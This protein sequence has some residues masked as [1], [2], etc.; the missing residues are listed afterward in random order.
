M[1]IYIGEDNY[2]TGIGDDICEGG[3]QYNGNIPMDIVLNCRYYRYI[4]G[5]FVLDEEAQAAGETTAALNRRIHEL[6]G[7][8]TSSDYI[9]AKLAE[10]T[11]QA[12]SSGDNTALSAML[13]EYADKIAQRQAWR[14]EISLLEKSL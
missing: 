14:D 3:I 10:A 12:Q 7:L 8:L 9:A 5:Q 6:K 1:K 13:A 4:D 11:A 2:I